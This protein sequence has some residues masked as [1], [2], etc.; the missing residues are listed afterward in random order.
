MGPQT[1]KHIKKLPDLLQDKA[2][3]LCPSIELRRRFKINNISRNE[4]RRH[5]KLS[6]PKVSFLEKALT[7]VQQMA[8][9]TVLNW[10]KAFENGGT[11]R[12]VHRRKLARAIRF[13]LSESI[14]PFLNTSTHSYTLLWQ[15][16]A[17]IYC[18]IL[19]WLSR[20]F[21]F[22]VHKKFMIFRCCSTVQT[23]VI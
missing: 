21:T 11:L 2:C 15:I 20:D 18:S 12:C 16:Q 3:F 8:C 1:L 14:Y 6:R 13:L 23:A 7:L 19:L 5:F 4:Y 10:K 9:R 17:S 22:S